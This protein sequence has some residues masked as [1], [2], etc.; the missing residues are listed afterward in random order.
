MAESPPQVIWLESSRSD[1]ERILHYIAAEN[2]L[3]AARM[4]QELLLAADSLTL[5]PHRGRAGLIPGTRELVIISPYVMIY[6]ISGQNEIRILRLWHSA[7][8]RF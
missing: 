4:A 3:A 8:D 1:L 2:P 7:Q 6:E 5:F